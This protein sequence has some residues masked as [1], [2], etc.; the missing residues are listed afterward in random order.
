[1]CF[2]LAWKS[3]K[4]YLIYEG[5]KEDAFVGP[6]SVLNVAFESNVIDN[7]QIWSDMLNDSNNIL[8]I[9]VEGKVS[10]LCKDIQKNICKN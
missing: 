4:E 1:M 8:N 7:E 10:R 5:Y 6:K 9:Y 2:E 3:L